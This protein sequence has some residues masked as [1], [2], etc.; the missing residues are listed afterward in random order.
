MIRMA[1]RPASRTVPSFIRIRTLADPHLGALLR[2]HRLDGAERSNLDL[3]LVSDVEEFW[4][5]V[6]HADA[7]R[8][9]GEQ[10]IARLKRERLGY[11]LDLRGNIE[12]HVA[13]IAV[14]A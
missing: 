10:E 13:G 2:D 12:D 3:H 6:A 14:L 9:T 5:I 8:R 7:L 4:G 1:S 11:M